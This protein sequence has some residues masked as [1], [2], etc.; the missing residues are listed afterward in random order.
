MPGFKTGMALGALLVGVPAVWLIMRIEGQPI[1]FAPSYIG[2][3]PDYVN[4]VGSVVGD[5]KFE[6]DRPINNGT[7]LTCF[8]PNETCKYLYINEISARQVGDIEEE[9]L[10]IRKWDANEL[11]ADSR[12]P[13]ATFEGC[14]YFEIRVLLISKDVTYMRLPNPKADKTRCDQLFKGSK[15]LRQWRIADG[16][17]WG[18]YEWGQR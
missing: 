9:M 11:V 7:K 4:V 1:T 18:E 16:K 14:N 10:Y 17:G 12:D 15:P 13:D 6:R 2:V 3:Q 5:D 8:R